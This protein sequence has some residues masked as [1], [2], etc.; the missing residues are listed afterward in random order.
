MRI[1]DSILRAR[2]LLHSLMV[3]LVQCDGV[4]VVILDVV[5]A[6]SIPLRQVLHFQV[7]QLL[8]DAQ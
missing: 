7:V 1:L 3:L 4:R 2:L 5:P 8:L 6:T